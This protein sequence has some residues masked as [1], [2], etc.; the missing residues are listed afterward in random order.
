MRQCGTVCRRY[1]ILL[2][3]LLHRETDDGEVPADVH[4][5]TAMKHVGMFNERNKF[6]VVTPFELV[7]AINYGEGMQRYIG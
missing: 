4:F 1:G 3:P 5:A 6:N 7:C 2:K